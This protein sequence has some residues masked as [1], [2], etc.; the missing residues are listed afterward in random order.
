MSTTYSVFTRVVGE[1]GLSE[2]FRKVGAAARMAFAPV[3]AFNKAVEAPSSNALGRV[4]AAADGVA[5]RFRSGLGSISAWLPA[6]GA[7]GSALTLGGLISMTRKSAEGFDDLAMSA[8]KLGLSSTKDL[9]VWRYGAKQTNVETEALQKG[10]VKL[11]KAMFDAS[12]GKNKDVAALF[13]AMKLP[14][15]DATG[16]VKGLEN[17]LEDIAEVFKNTHDEETKNAA[18]LALFGKAGAD[19]IPFLNRGR[20]GI[21]AWREEMKRFSGLTETHKLSLGELDTAYKRLDKAGS[22]LAS[23]LSAAVA[24]ALTA[25]VNWTT[26]WIA[27]NRELIAQ[28][29]ERKIVKI[30]GAFEVLAGIGK[31]VLAVPWV[32][33]F[34]KGADAG[35]MF[36]LALG[37]LGLTMTGPLFAAIGVVTKAAWAMNRAMW[38]NPWVL[39]AAGI[40]FAAYEVYAHWG[41]IKSWWSETMDAIHA[42]SERGFAAEVW[43]TY[44]QSMMILPRAVNTMVK[45]LTGI[46]LFAIGRNMIAG[47]IAG[48]KSLLPDL[49]G[50]WAKVQ[51]AFNWVSRNTSSVTP[52]GS[53]QDTAG[54]YREAY[55]DRFPQAPS[56]GSPAA[57]GLAVPQKSEVTVKVD[58]ANTPPGANVSING[59]DGVKIQRNVGYS[60]QDNT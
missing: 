26:D 10:L 14:L 8:E 46:D 37:G 1:D 52:T 42:A 30:S 60:M 27:A 45:D 29:L 39:L 25:V 40:A 16:H 48:L 2:V 31:Q 43:E 15:R 38:A 50:T 17:S 33:E 7:L 23:R 24:P 3:H 32:A 54:G 44:S 21:V 9:S 18:A 28:S 58:F 36:D 11:R 53:A 51:P 49:D 57:M 47:L 12:T 13:A 59:S 22:G 6:L 41:D 56:P 4:G 20:A 55:A 5:G 19:L 34:W 35:T